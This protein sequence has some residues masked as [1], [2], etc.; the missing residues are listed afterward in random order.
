ML[1]RMFRGRESNAPGP[2]RSLTEKFRAL[3]AAGSDP[4]AALDSGDTLLHLAAGS[5]HVHLVTL[6]LSSQ[7][8]R[9]CA[10]SPLQA[11]CCLLAHLQTEM[12]PMC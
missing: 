1:P 4:R 9:G 8:C 11:T 6:L 7:V 2:N 12:L 5:A 3:L 10:P